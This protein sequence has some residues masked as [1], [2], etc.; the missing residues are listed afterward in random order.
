MKILFGKIIIIVLLITMVSIKEMYSIN[1]SAENKTITTSKIGL[2]EA[3][4]ENPD[5]L[6]NR[7]KILE[8][9]DKILKTNISDYAEYPST[10]R[11]FFI[12]DLTDPTNNYL[13]WGD[14]INFISNHVY[15]FSVVYFAFSQSQIAVLENGDV[16][17]FNSINCQDSKDKLENVI[18]YLSRKL[19]ND[20]NKEEILTRVKN[21]RRYGWHRTV[22]EFRVGCNS[23]IRIPENPDKFY[24]RWKVL[25]E[26]ADFIDS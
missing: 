5:S 12:Y 9:F 24:D 10:A 6:Y 2:M 4:S 8:R 26:M 13:T 15:Y 25:V 23:D 21:Y 16:K 14:C 11:G 18:S 17:F 1:K 22:D 20:K 3:C 19:K 7:E